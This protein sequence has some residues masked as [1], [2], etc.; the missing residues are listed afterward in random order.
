MNGVMKFRYILLGLCIGIALGLG[1]A[2]QA[3]GPEFSGAMQVFQ[4]A[5]SVQPRPSPSDN[6]TWKD[7]NGKILNL[8]NFKGKVILINYW[9]TWCPPCIRELPS[10]D[11]LQARLGGDDFTIVAISIDR[12]GKPIA[13]RLMKHL[14]LKN[15]ALYLDPTSKSAKKLGVRS[16]PTTFLFDR[17]GREIGKLEGGAEWDDKEA[18]AL[19]QYFI[20]NQAHADALPLKK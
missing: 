6:A 5:P 4:L 12:G 9:A 15:L 7:A 2:A 8:A 11:R 14:R 16:M 1:N 3:K 19:I 17:K 18:I 20:D 13:R 10:I